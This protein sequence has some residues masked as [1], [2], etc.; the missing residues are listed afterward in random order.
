G[1]AGAR[2]DQAR[3]H[4]GR[5]TPAESRF[6]KRRAPGLWPGV[7]TPYWLLSR[8]VILPGTN[9]NH[10]PRLQMINGS[11]PGHL[12]VGGPLVV[13]IALA[14]SRSPRSPPMARQ[15]GKPGGVPRRRVSFFQA[16]CSIPSAHVAQLDN[17]PDY[18]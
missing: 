9:R 14:A 17:V 11:L 12:W 7:S 16:P 10:L 13:P 3:P 2:P 8:L 4:T 1:S 5:L 15:S 18:E 6:S